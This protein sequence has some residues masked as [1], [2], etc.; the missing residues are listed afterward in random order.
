MLQSAAF[1][2]PSLPVVPL[3]GCSLSSA[4]A[5]AQR[6]QAVPALPVSRAL[7][8]W[9]V[10]QNITID[11]FRTKILDLMLF[12]QKILDLMLFV[13]NSANQDKSIKYCFRAQVSKCT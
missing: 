3:P 7:N 6:L 13:F 2:V 1:C 10:T 5:Y 12:V 11:A 4:Q 8:F 9:K